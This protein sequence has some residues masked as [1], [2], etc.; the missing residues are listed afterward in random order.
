MG[1][2]TGA[3]DAPGRGDRSDQHPPASRSAT[4]QA[5]SLG[6][7]RAIVRLARSWLADELTPLTYP[8]HKVG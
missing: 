8:A 6:G 3:A 7:T 2:A 5:A 1:I 4:T